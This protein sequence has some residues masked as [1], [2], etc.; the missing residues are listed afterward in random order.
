MHRLDPGTAL[1]IDERSASV[2]EERYWSWPDGSRVDTRPEAEAIEAIRAA[3]DE[4]VRIRMRSDVPLGAF[5]S[6]GM[7]SAAVLALMARHSS[8]P[9]K[10]FTIGFGDPQYDELDDARST[11]AFFG[12]EHHE[13]VVTPDAIAV[14]ESLAHHYDEPFAD[15]SAIPTYYV[16]QQ[17][18]RHVTVCLSGDGGDELFAGYTPYASALARQGVP[19]AV[20]TSARSMTRKK[21]I[22]WR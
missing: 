6:G 5:L 17:A 16:A 18:R 11:A 1:I 4:S 2:T 22:S 9:I 21:E 12:A 13:Q 8:Q 14:A 15:A 3:I 19:R 10:T 20:G 7:D